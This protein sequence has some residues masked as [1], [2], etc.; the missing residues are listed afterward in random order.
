VAARG[1]RG[2][3]SRSAARRHGRTRA[4]ARRG[5]HRADGAPGARSPRV[6]PS[7]LES[8]VVLP[9][10][11][12]LDRSVRNRRV[13]RAPAVGARGSRHRRRGGLARG[14][15][16]LGSRGRSRSG[17]PDV[18]A[19]A[20][21]VLRRGA[22]VRVGRTPGRAGR[23]FGGGLDEP[24]DPSTRDS[25]G[26]A[27]RVLPVH[28]LLRAVRRG[29]GASRRAVARAETE[30]RVDGARS[31]DRLR[32]LG[33]DPAPPARAVCRVPVL[34]GA[35]LGTGRPCRRVEG[36]GRGMVVR[37]SVHPVA[38]GRSGPRMD[39]SRAPRRGGRGHSSSLPRRARPSRP[40]E[41]VLR[42]DSRRL[43]L[44]D[45]HLAPDV[46]SRPP[47]P[48]RVPRVRDA[49]GRG[50][51]S[52]PGEDALGGDAGRD[53]RVAVRDR[54]ELR[55]GRS[56]D[57]SAAARRGPGSRRSRERAGVRSAVSRA[58]GVL[59]DRSGVGRVLVSVGL[60]RSHGQSQPARVRADRSER[61][62][63]PAVR[64]VGP[65]RPRDGRRRPAAVR[66]ER[67]VSAALRRA[68]RR[69][70]RSRSRPGQVSSAAR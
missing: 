47:R 25:R 2:R 36:L 55:H 1:H 50:A 43:G 60:R 13:R 38:A 29:G 52:G 14:S 49:A 10:S 54:A 7:R 12:R 48:A 34:A 28:A 57:G 51:R 45:R 65:G 44:L 15:A 4:V 22:P 35:I 33:P 56:G 26:D 19:G 69:R 30:R 63:R 46:H 41:R 21:R 31:G 70:L 42:F 64:D 11:E 53:E 32:V 27:V 8:P 6:A 17:A 24:S 9:A 40:V 66:G 68:P 67:L 18:L 37:R 20:H 62:R 59:P 16:V 5:E 61:R 3:R 39:R 23:D 58:R